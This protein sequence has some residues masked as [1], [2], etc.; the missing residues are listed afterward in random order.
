IVIN[1]LKNEPSLSVSATDPVNCGASGTATVS[2]SNAGTITWYS[3][4]NPSSAITTTSGLT[5]SGL[6]AGSYMVENQYG[7]CLTTANF[8]IAD[9]VINVSHNS[10]AGACAGATTPA[11]INAQF[12]PA[13]SATYNYT[14]YAMPSGTTI[15]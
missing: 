3:Q 6:S 11:T 9:P 10:G 14:L 2:T 15:S 7:S 8:N 4:A 1:I 13:M 12:S 5:A